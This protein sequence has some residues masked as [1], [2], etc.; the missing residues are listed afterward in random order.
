VTVF[1]LA[2]SIQD[3]LGVT[4][5]PTYAPARAGEVRRSIGDPT[6]ARAVLGFE[7]TV[8]LGSG[9]EELLLNNGSAQVQR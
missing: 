9:L 2:R 5:E 8:N 1:N 6:L 3:L 7:A 4:I